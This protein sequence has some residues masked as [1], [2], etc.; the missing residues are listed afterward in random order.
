MILDQINYERLLIPLN[1]FYD[2][3]IGGPRRP[4]FYDIAATR[5]ELLELDR[6]Y[7]VIREELLGI[8]PDK[9]SI[10]RYHELDEMQYNI[11]AR[12]RRRRTGRSTRWTS[13]GPG[14]RRSARCPR[15]TALLD[16]IPGLFEA[17]FSILE[18][19][20]S[21]PPHEGPYR[22]Y[23]RYHLGLVVPDKDPPSI[24]LKDQIY[25]WKEGESVLFDDSWEHEVYN[26]C[27]RDRVV[28][29]V[30]IRRPMPQPFDAVN[31]LAQSIMKPVYGRAI[32]RRLAAMTSPRPPRFRRDHGPRV[33]LPVMRWPERRWGGSAGCCSPPRRSPI[34][35]ARPSRSW[36]STVCRRN[37]ASVTN[38]SPA[39]SPHS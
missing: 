12:W 9:R 35:T 2:L 14:R 32:I 16:G 20:K 33:R 18:G 17:F 38:R 28:L 34:S 30:D 5:P 21:I 1:K 37:T 24:R 15:T 3:Y 13:W 7:P 36:R 8:L 29:I 27:D 10:P 6:N 39:S 22:G 25:T 23:L 4:V 26:Q 19:G 11:S 31:R